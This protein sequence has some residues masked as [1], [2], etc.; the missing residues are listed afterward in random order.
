LPDNK[1]V[2]LTGVVPEVA[3]RLVEV[4]RLL[5]AQPELAFRE[6]KTSAYLAEQL[7][8]AGLDLRKAVAQTGLVATLQGSSPGKTVLVRADMDGLPIEEPE[9]ESFRSTHQRT[10]HACG[11]DV[12]MAIA[13][14]LAEQFAKQK[15]NLAGSVRFAFQPAEEVAGGAKPMIEAGVLEGVD[16]VIGLH[17]WAG[18]RTGAVSV[19]KGAMMASA[20]WFTLNVVG[21][22][23]HGAQPHLAVDPIVTAAQIVTALQTLVSR[24]TSPLSPVVVTIGS[25]A[26]GQVHNVIP[27]EVVMRGTLRTFDPELR[28]RLLRRIE[29]LSREVAKAFLADCRFKQE[30][31]APPV[32][33]DD[34]I[35]DLVGESARQTLGQDALDPF[36]PLLV[37][38]DVSLFLEERPGCFFLLGGAPVDGPRPHHS[39]EFKIDEACLGVGYRVMEAALGR[40]LQ[41]V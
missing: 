18:L 22:G 8:K 3:A 6:E 14:T 34:A 41:C 4:R 7:S 15:Q 10:M 9:G 24:E 38:E 2:A 19:R 5:H 11:H 39:P 23:G 36:E 37:G 40:L 26:G 21:K 27:S 32:V 12:H 29:D 31:G 35:A 17:V 1:Q 28:S 33:N 13:L 16:T 20:D 25:I 30:S